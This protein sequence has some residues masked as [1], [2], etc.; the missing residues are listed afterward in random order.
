MHDMSVRYDEL[1]TFIGLSKQT[2]PLITYY[3]ER[4]LAYTDYMKYGEYVDLCTNRMERASAIGITVLGKVVAL[5]DMMHPIPLTMEPFYQYLDQ[6]G[7]PKRTVPAVFGPA[8]DDSYMC[9]GLTPDKLPKIEFDT[10]WIT[11]L[12]KYNHQHLSVGINPPIVAWLVFEKL[13]GRA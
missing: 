9:H 6:M 8:K 4:L 1:A 2:I 11:T 10:D 5:S 3:N 12:D 13:E 7:M